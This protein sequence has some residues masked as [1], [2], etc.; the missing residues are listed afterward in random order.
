MGGMIGAMAPTS[1]GSGAPALVFVHGWSCDRSYWDGQL[2]WFSARHQVVAMDLA[3]H[4]ESGAGREAWTMAAFGDDVVAVVQALGLGEVVLIGHSMG[5]DVVVEAALRLPDQVVG[6]V[7][8][9]VYTRLDEPQARVEV[10]RFLTPL[11]EDFGTAARQLVWRMFPP[12]ADA[13][14]VDRVADGMSPSP[15]EIAIE[16]ADHAVSNDRHIRAR[17]GRLTCRSSPS[18]PA[19]GPPTPNPSAGTASAP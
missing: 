16:V 10:E 17:L 14:L 7:W 11:R 9:D 1:R 3:G 8:A 13:E 4:G 5:G 18:T 19:A 6:L 12:G 15:P 2:D